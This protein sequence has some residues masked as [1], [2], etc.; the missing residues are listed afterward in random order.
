[1]N[2]K[3]PKSQVI[4]SD[5]HPRVLDDEVK[6]ASYVSDS[7]QVNAATVRLVGRN[8]VIHHV[9]LDDPWSRNYLQN[10]V[11]LSTTGISRFAR[12]MKTVISSIMD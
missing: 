12:N 5:I 8:N 1:M 11:Q 6:T 9:N 7:R 2:E 3:F 10:G 4:H